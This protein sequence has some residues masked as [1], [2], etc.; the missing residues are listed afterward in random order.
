LNEKI[1]PI[2]NNPSVQKISLEKYKEIDIERQK[3]EEKLPQLNKL[4]INDKL[5]NIIKRKTNG[6]FDYVYCYE[7]SCKKQF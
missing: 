2:Q 4:H 7:W 6:I 5:E 1:L 3:N